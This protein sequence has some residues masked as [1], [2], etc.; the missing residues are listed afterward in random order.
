MWTLLEVEKGRHFKTNNL[1][2]KVQIERSKRYCRLCNNGVVEDEVHFL[3]SCPAL[4]QTRQT[5]LDRLTNICPD[6]ALAPH[7]DK[8]MYLYFNEDLGKEELT[9]AT[10]LLS[11]LKDARDNYLLHWITVEKW[12]Q[13]QEWLPHPEMYRCLF[14]V[15]LFVSY[16]V[17]LYICHSALISICAINV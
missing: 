15:Y 3:F 2:K 5:H 14:V 11:S 16:S 9:L 13:C 12:P 1:G 17:P 8:L 4:T 10:N 6:L 7:Q